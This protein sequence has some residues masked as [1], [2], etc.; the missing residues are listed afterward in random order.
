MSFRSHLCRRSFSVSS[1]HPFKVP[2]EYEGAFKGGSLP[3]QK[4]IQYTDYSLKKFFKQVSTMPW[5]K[6]TI[7]VITADHTSSD[8]YFDESRTA[9]GYYSVPVIFY[10]PDNSLTEMSTDIA[11]QIDI[12]PSVLGHL[13]YD[14]PYVAF[15]RDVFR[16]TTEPFAFNYNEVYQLTKGEYILQFDGKKAISLYNFRKDPLLR[17]N[18]HTEQPEVVASMEN[19]I[20]AVIQ[21]YSNRMIEDKLSIKK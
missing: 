9:W 14:K 8:I 20:K 21:Q 13:H 15:G 16:E 12:M 2:T 11:Q 18:L 3:I 6:N 10:K 5:F 4:C 17:S 1:H 7:F 19:F